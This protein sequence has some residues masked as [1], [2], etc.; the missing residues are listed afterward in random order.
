M[1]SGATWEAIDTMSN[2]G[3]SACAKTVDGFRKKVQKEYVLKVEQ[4]F[5][6]MYINYY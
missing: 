2:L 6:K 4:H 3:Y 5:I 1:A